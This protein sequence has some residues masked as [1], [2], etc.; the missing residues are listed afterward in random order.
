MRL[1][2]FL[3]LAC[4]S[5]ALAVPSKTSAPPAP[6][7]DPVPA[8]SPAGP[9]LIRKSLVRIQTVSQDPDY[10]EPWN[11]GIIG[12][13]IGAGFVIDGERILTN[14]HVVSNARMIWI[15]REGDPNR[16]PARVLHIAH[17][18][19]LAVL[20]PL[21]RDFFKGMRPL[22]FDSLPQIESTVSVYGYPIGGDHPSVTR[23]V[24]S[25]IDFQDYSH[26]GADSHL[27]IQI[28]AAIN[29]GNSGGPVV[30][31]GKVV[32]VAFQGYSGDVAQNTGYMIPTPVIKRFLS[33]I[34]DGH[35]DHYMDLA[36]STFPLDNP[37]ARHAL[38]LADDSRGVFVSSV[39]GGGSSDGILKPGDVILSID[40][41]SVASDGSVELDGSNVQMAEVVERKFK[42]DKVKLR[43][44]RDG[45][46]LDVTVPLNAPYPFTLFANAYD[47]K[48]R[49]IE[50]AGL[51][52]QPLDQ[53]FVS[54]TQLTNFRTRY[55]FDR[56]LEDDLYKER[57]EI[58]I[59][60]SILS[61]PV[62]AYAGEFRQA[63]VDSINGKKIRALDDVAAALSEPAKDY[64]IEFLGASRPL[65]LEA[66]AV[67][68][69]RARID[70][71]YGIRKESNLKP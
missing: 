10:T 69:A 22:E 26:S 4:A 65:V 60:S 36:V 49:Y 31:D 9:S 21:N 27:V 38:G 64:V 20:R 53:N 34:A 29:P 13:G 56:F 43:I 40:G 5:A 3:L 71:R 2:I 15:T 46:P 19:D 59:L 6:P 63:I 1:P 61:D 35:Y 62:N 45:K 67:A 33:D 11:S 18:C 12:Q 23:G 8:A 28:D 54:S 48:P 52:F 41:H 44:V 57:P 39:F 68:D 70:A 42:G 7:P 16:Y 66:K 14:A 50:F 55:T 24:V 47:V 17:D 37:A 30:Q 58:V 51:V 32:G 25:R